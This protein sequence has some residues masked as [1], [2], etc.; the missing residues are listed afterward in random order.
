MYNDTYDTNYKTCKLS[1]GDK[2]KNTGCLVTRRLIRKRLGKT[3]HGNKIVLY[4]NHDVGFTSLNY[5]LKICAFD[6]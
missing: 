1:Y 5:T 3:Y 4:I 6:V 2:H